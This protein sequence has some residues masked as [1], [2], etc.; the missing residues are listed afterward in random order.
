M[1]GFS[2]PELAQ[3][4]GKSQRYIIELC[5][6]GKVEADLAPASGRGS[7]RRFSYA[8]VLQAALALH[9]R[10]KLGFSWEG[11]RRQSWFL[12]NL[13]KSPD[14]IETI[15]GGTLLIFNPE[16]ELQALGSF[17]PFS[18]EDLLG[19]RRDMIPKVTPV[20]GL[21][22]IDL[23]SIKAAVDQRIAEL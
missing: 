20:T 9:L 5:E 2:T 18:L 8:S 19:N 10:H 16:N 22:M 14:L 17:F 1:R 7:R 15:M 13:T 12:S 23:S 6:K 21:I 4:L 3:I 11:M